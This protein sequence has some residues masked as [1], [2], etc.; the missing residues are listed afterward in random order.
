MR[1]PDLDEKTLA[2]GVDDVMGGVVCPNVCLVADGGC[3][4]VYGAL[5]GAGKR[6]SQD[7]FWGLR[8]GGRGGVWQQRVGERGRP[9]GRDTVVD[10][11][12]EP[13]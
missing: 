8:T 9:P 1:A 4:V 7:A 3:G 5:G 6:A 12:E 10:V 11:T 13:S 2:A